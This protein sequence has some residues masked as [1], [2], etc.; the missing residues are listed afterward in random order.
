MDISLRSMLWTKK[1]K[2]KYIINGS[3]ILINTTHYDVSARAYSHILFY[4]TCY[5]QTKFNI[6]VKL[7]KENKYPGRNMEVDKNGHTLNKSICYN[8]YY[9]I[10]I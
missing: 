3:Y 10:I 1:I 9:I 6:D 7:S 4:D 2:E 8:K 5:P